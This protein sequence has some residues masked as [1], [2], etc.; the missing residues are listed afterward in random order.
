MTELEVLYKDLDRQEQ[1]LYKQLQ[2]IESLE[3]ELAESREE[4]RRLTERG[5]LIEWAIETASVWDVFLF[6]TDAEE[7]PSKAL[8]VTLNVLASKVSDYKHHAA[9]LAP[10]AGDK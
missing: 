10:K 2:Q 3:Q 8:I 9:L 6:N 4:C 7:P 5:S 1:R